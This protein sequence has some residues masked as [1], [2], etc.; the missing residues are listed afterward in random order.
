M[1]A[2]STTADERARNIERIMLQRFSE[3]TQAAI[4]LETNASEASISRFKNDS[5][6]DVAKIIVALGLKVV[7]EK[8][9]VVKEE[10]L[11]TYKKMAL[12]YLALDLNI[13][14]N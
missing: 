5:M 9:R 13:N 11:I 6:K 4:A 8:D 3:K 2:L 1:N 10:D 14:I 12:K 7:D